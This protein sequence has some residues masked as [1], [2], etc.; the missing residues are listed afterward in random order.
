MFFKQPMNQFSEV[1]FFLQMTKFLS[2]TMFTANESRYYD[3][4]F[5]LNIKKTPKKKMKTQN[6][7][8]LVTTDLCMITY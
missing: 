5:L 4:D 1:N 8:H 7:F 2:P 6:I 3:Y